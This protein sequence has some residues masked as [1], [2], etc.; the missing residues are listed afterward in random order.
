MAHATELG[1]FLRS[2]RDRLS[3]EQPQ[4][5]RSAGRRRVPG[6]RREELAR[7]AGVSVDYYTR[8]E[9]GR[10]RNA[11][12]E[13]LAAIARALRLDETERTHLLD[14]AGAGPARGHPPRRPQR[15]ARETY[16]LLESLE[17]GG[18]PAFVIGRCCDVLAAN[19]L[20]RA[21]CCDFYAMPAAER[22][23]ARYIFCDPRARRLHDDWEGVAANVAAILKFE[24][25]RRP[26]DPRLAE[27]IHGLTKD[28]AD[29]RRLWARYDVHERV[30]GIK[31]YDNPIV[32]DIVMTY[33]TLSLPG[34]P[35]QTLFIYTVEPGTPSA[36]AMRLLVK[37]VE[38]G[39]IPAGSETRKDRRSPGGAA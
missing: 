30:R 4:D 31:R 1:E 29:F 39:N 11:S 28:S 17:Q 23:M 19:R 2:R 9:Q 22:N 13:V 24:F 20:L 25:G 18:I 37:Y 34:D 12:R 36:E 16:Q 8:L 3:P 6:L 5:D 35:D 26:D 21:L 7:M 33:H 10:S 15:V 14:L 32:G 38:E 27:V